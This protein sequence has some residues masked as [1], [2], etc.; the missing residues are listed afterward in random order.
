MVLEGLPG[1]RGHRDGDPSFAGL[2]S[3]CSPLRM[4]H[5]L[6]RNREISPQAPK[7]RESTLVADDKLELGTRAGVESRRLNFFAR[8]SR[9]TNASVTRHAVVVQAEVGQEVKAELSAV[10]AE[11]S[12]VQPT[13]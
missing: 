5:L 6:R 3:S 11:L 12:A 1:A 4:L 2:P 8:E 13:A 9:K 10:K 7:L